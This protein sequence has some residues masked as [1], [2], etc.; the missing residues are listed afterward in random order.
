MSDYSEKEHVLNSVES[1][2]S[3]RLYSVAPN[4]LRHL[5]QVVPAVGTVEAQTVTPIKGVVRMNLD[6]QSAAETE[7]GNLGDYSR[8]VIEKLFEEKNAA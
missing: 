7:H 3:Q 8:D 4:S 1:M 2:R 6:E 5:D